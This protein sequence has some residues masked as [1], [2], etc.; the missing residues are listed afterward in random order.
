[1]LSMQGVTKTYLKSYR[2][3]Q[4]Q[5]T[6]LRSVSLSIREGEFVCVAG[7]SGSGKSTLLSL[8]G[9]LDR[10]TCGAYQFDGVDVGSLRDEQMSAMR[11][12]KIGFVFQSFN[13]LPELTLY[14]N[15]EAPLR[16]QRT[17]FRQRRERVTAMLDTFGLGARAQH[18]PAEV[19]GGQQQRAA[20]A[21]AI[22]AKPRVILADEPTGNLDSEMSLQTLQLLRDIHASGVTLVLV[23]HDE[24][25]ARVADR[26][27][28]IVDGTLVG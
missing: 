25:I 4:M 15:I 6:A 11:L 3:G 2:G 21:R 28:E 7:P 27:I 14:Q 19:S 10:H 12:E 9:L 23:T 16:Y 18:Y 8:F 5:T 26:V 22:V 1:V 17:S 13:L 20:I 24:A